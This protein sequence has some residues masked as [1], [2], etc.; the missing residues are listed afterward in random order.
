MLS[1]LFIKYFS[2]ESGANVSMAIINLHKTCKPNCKLRTTIQREEDYGERGF[3]LVNFSSKNPDHNK[4]LYEYKLD[5]NKNEY[6]N[7]LW[8]T[9]PRNILHDEKKGLR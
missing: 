2:S 6:L 8:D 1:S 9:I 5:D 7:K 4:L 3:F